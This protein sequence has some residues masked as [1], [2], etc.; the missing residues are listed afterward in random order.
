MNHSRMTV[1][2]PGARRAFGRA[3]AVSALAATIGCFALS[4]L[5]HAQQSAVRQACA[6]D[7]RTYC[8]DVRPGGGRI[9]ACLKRNADKLSQDCRQALAGLKA[10]H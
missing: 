6:A 2:R 9:A 4:N 7:Y 8:S 10:Q 3:I 1:M 5:A